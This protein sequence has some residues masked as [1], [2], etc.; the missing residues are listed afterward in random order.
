MHTLCMTVVKKVITVETDAQKHVIQ[1]DL[2]QRDLQGENFF[3]I[4]IWIRCLH[5]KI[6]Y[7]SVF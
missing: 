5:I 6:I 3:W 4:Q 2:S 1:S 7:T